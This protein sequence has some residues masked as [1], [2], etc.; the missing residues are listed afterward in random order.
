MPYNIF[1]VAPANTGQPM[2]MPVPYYMQAMSQTMPTMVQPM[3]Q[4]MMTQMYG[5]TQMMQQPG[6]TAQQP[7]MATQQSA[8]YQQNRGNLGRLESVDDVVVPAA[9]EMVHA[10]PSVQLHAAPP[11]SDHRKQTDKQYKD[12]DAEALSALEEFQ[13]LHD[14]G[15]LKGQSSYAGSVNEE[16]LEETR[17]EV[18]EHAIDMDEMIR[19]LDEMNAPN[20]Q[21]QTTIDMH[22]MDEIVAVDQRQEE[23]APGAF[24]EGSDVEET[25]QETRQVEVESAIDIEAMLQKLDEMD[26]TPKDHRVDVVDGGDDWEVMAASNVAVTESGLAM[27]GF[28]DSDE[29]DG[30]LR[31]DGHLVHLYGKP[32]PT[33]M[34]MKARLE[35]MERR[36]HFIEESVH[37]DSDEDLVQKTDSLKIEYAP[38]PSFDIEEDDVSME[39]IGRT[40]SA[41]VEHPPPSLQNSWNEPAMQDYP[42][43]DDDDVIMPVRT[44]RRKLTP[45]P[46]PRGRPRKQVEVEAPVMLLLD[47]VDSF[48]EE[49]VAVE[50]TEQ[51][52]SVPAVFE[53]EVITVER[54]E[55]NESAPTDD[56]GG[57]EEEVVSV[58]QTEQVESV[59][60]GFEEEVITVERTEQIESAP[61]DFEITAPPAGIPEITVEEVVE[62]KSEETETVSV[63]IATSA[64]AIEASP[65]V[66]EE[67]FEVE[68]PDLDL[69]SEVNQESQMVDG[70]DAVVMETVLEVEAAPIA[71]EAELFPEDKK[72]KKKKTKKKKEK[73]EKKQKT[74]K[75][76]VDDDGE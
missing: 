72:G 48:E 20:S 2:M 50:R 7:G 67:T 71:M 12:L 5:N 60:A 75:K 3:V 76:K 26:R 16:P 24:S 17:Q 11:P 35:I 15:A 56:G 66:I 1:M 41:P 30:T 21:E 61:A 47:D 65:V 36:V 63:V 68:K 13:R 29:G 46:P 44:V 43:D 57:F 64:V 10:A 31:D 25:M 45:T 39:T 19:K 74:K 14:S 52:E 53:E 58:E 27:D 62:T 70:E 4:P 9:Q 69:H 8:G 37:L 54:T 22:G 6:M 59:P 18:V 40:E 32:D 49:V 55:Q 28:L 33:E 73:K 42:S 38:Q 51:V 23:S 34:A